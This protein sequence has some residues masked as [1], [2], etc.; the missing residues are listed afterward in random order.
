MS[1]NNEAMMQTIQLLKQQILW[2][3]IMAIGVAICVLAV[4]IGLAMALPWILDTANDTQALLNETTKTVGYAQK[5]FENL[6]HIT[7]GVVGEDLKELTDGLN[8]LVKESSEGLQI[9]FSQLGN[10][11]LSVLNE[12]IADL[13]QAI[14]PLANFA[15]AFG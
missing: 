3:R 5:V 10:I 12:A 4:G 8:E 7:E 14:E 6:S 9:I 15:R 11:D 13:Q 1:K 2:T